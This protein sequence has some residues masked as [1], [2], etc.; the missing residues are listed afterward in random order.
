MS[1][2]PVPYAVVIASILL[3]TGIIVSVIVFGGKMIGP[4]LEEEK[5]KIEAWIAFKDLNQYGDPKDKVYAGGSPLF[6]ESSG[7]M[8]D[9]YEYIRSNHR[10]R[11]WNDIDPKWLSSLAPGEYERFDSWI[12]ANDLNQYGDTKD[13]MYLG[14]NPLFLEGLGKNITLDEYVLGRHP[15]RPWNR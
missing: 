8:L 7:E 1:R 11:P 3:I 12:K 2:K 10:D 13:Q 5:P 9:H 14:G 4:V 6:D 15:D